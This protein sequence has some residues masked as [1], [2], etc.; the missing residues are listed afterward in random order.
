LNR[1][2]AL[3]VVVTLVWGT[4]FPIVRSVSAHLS[5]LEIS[6]LRFV[7]AGACM[8]PFAL[9]ASRSA[10]RDGALLGSVA[11]VSY[12]AQAVGLGHISSNRSA[13]LTS[14]NILMVP[15]FGLLAGGRLSWQVVGAALLACIG[16]G[17][18]SWESGGEP[19]GDAATLLCAATYAIY[20]ILLSRRSPAHPSR[21]LA[22]TQI[23]SMAMISVPCLLVLGYRDGSLVSLSGRT[24]PVATSI[25]YL[26]AI[27][28]AAMLFLQAIGQRILS[29]SKAAVIYALE[30]VFAALFGW[31]WLQES[32][33]P[34]SFAG[35]ALVILAVIL[36]EWRFSSST[37]LA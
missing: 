16:I 22:A 23:L 19:V 8:L 2:V 28:S 27:A 5:G 13:F 26:G 20:V 32:M 17:L 37:A 18:M 30:P 12:V 11:L 14:T 7:V 35:A 3:L 34:R 10:W 21:H 24:A 36:A 29:A 4:T 6:A 1:G 9:G 25:L 31:W 33:G 15:F